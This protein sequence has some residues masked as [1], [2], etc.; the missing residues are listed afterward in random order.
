MLR[1]ILIAN[2]KLKPEQALY[3]TSL[4]TMTKYA[5]LLRGVNIGGNNKAPTL[6]EA[7][8]SFDA[9]EEH[10]DGFYIHCYCS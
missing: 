9:T 4:V 1:Q 2:Q 3:F 6:R 5:A 8:T 7:E 10:S